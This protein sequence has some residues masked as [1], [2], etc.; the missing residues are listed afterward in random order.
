MS[1]I[2]KRFT[3]APEL[4]SGLRNTIQSAS[5]NQGQLHYDMMSLDSIEPDPYN[6]RKLLLSKNQLLSGTHAL[7]SQEQKEYDALNELAESIKRIGVKNAIEVYKEGLIYRIITGERRYLAALLAGQKTIPVR[8]SQKPDEFNLRYTQ[9]IENINRKDLTLWEKLNNLRLIAEAYRKSN[10]QE[11]S[12]QVLQKLLG[13]SN[14]QAYRYFSLLKANHKIIELVQLGRLNNL[15]IVQELVTMKDQAASNQI[16]AWILASKKEITSIAHYRRV[17]GKSASRTLSKSTIS[18]SLERENAFLA[19]KKIFDLVLSDLRLIKY[20]HDFREVNW[21]SKKSITK[22]LKNLLLT[23][24][25]EF[26][27]EVSL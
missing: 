27:S 24:E 25:N 21:S 8:I 2:K 10:R 1:T 4:A 16:I 18:I 6:P 5:T 7:T 11:L 14:I 17:A 19:I 20:R 12:E 22:A 15:K 9:W 13:I 23:V 26:D 3:I